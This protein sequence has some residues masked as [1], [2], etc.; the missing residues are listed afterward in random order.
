MDRIDGLVSSGSVHRTYCYVIRRKGKWRGD[1]SERAV[2]HVRAWRPEETSLPLLGPA[3]TP[4]A[5]WAPRISSLLDFV[6]CGKWG[7]KTFSAMLILQRR[8]S[9]PQERKPKTPGGL[10]P[11][12]L[13]RCWAILGADSQPLW[14]QHGRELGRTALQ[15]SGLPLSESWI[16]SGCFCSVLGAAAFLE[17]L[18]TR[19][20]LGPA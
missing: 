1:S 15:D 5:C 7:G 8:F 13:G 20:P 19:H 3:H 16:L 2:E 14:T 6:L 18:R 9:K 12:L 17:Q 10:E 4:G 11:D